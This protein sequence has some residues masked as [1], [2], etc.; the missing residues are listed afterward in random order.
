MARIIVFGVL[1]T[2]WTFV[3]LILLAFVLGGSGIT[4][5]AAALL[6][7]FDPQ[8]VANA[9][10]EYGSLAVFLVWLTGTI[11]LVLIAWAMRAMRGSVVV[12]TAGSVGERPMKDVTPPRGD[13]PAAPH[14]DVSQDNRSLPP[15]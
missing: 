5:V 8:Q 2:L 10:A 6:T 4:A 1:G 12:V 13:R 9:I 7:N 14:T 3:C 15:R 11:V